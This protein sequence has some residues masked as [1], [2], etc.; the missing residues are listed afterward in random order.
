[1]KDILKGYITGLL[2]AVL[3]ISGISAIAA[4]VN[5]DMGGIKVFW[6]GIEINLPDAN[7]NK[8]EPFIYNGTTYV[9]LRAMAN[10]MGEEVEWDQ[11][12]MAV[13][14]DGKPSGTVVTISEFPESKIGAR[15]GSGGDNWMSHDIQK[16][17]E[18]QLKDKT[19]SVSNLIVGDGHYSLGMRDKYGSYAYVHG[20]PYYQFDLNGQYSRFR[21]K[22]V[23]P[24]TEIGSRQKGLITFYSI[25]DDGTIDELESY[26]LQQT[27]DEIDIDIN[28]RGISRLRIMWGTEEENNP[29]NYGEIAL[30][31]MEFVAR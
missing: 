4:N 30:Y 25:S 20:G 9:P 27:E 12:N 3:V 7:G 16:K 8:V 22:A 18:F 6:D 29:Y 15:R 11:R 2:V 28:L 24:Y 17:G 5:V 19:I 31:D 13:Y 1:M 14:I 10:L 26:E 23:M 21:A